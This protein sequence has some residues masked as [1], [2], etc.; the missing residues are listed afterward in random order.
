MYLGETSPMVNST[1]FIIHS[2]DTLYSFLYWNKKYLYNIRKVDELIKRISD[3]TDDKY[4][5]KQDSM[6]PH[7]E[8]R[9]DKNENE[10]GNEKIIKDKNEL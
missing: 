6:H 5:V 9:V 10:N 3:I 7:I 2:Q 1:Y 4:Y 8:Y